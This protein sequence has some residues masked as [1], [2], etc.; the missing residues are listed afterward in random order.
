MATQE[1]ITEL[2]MLFCQAK[3]ERVQRALTE[4]KSQMMQEMEVCI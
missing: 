1:D 4:L 3:R 2:D